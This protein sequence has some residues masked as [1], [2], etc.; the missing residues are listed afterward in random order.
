[1]FSKCFCIFVFSFIPLLINLL[2]VIQSHRVKLE[3]PAVEPQ[4]NSGSTDR[5]SRW[6]WSDVFYRPMFIMPAPQ[7]ETAE[8]SRST[9]RQSC[10]SKTVTN[11][12]AESSGQSHH[13]KYYM[14]SDPDP[15][16]QLHGSF[17]QLLISGFWDFLW[18]FFRFRHGYCKGNP[19]KMVRTW[20]EKE[21]RNLI[22]S[23]AL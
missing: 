18:F 15:V 5:F 13:S 16:S 19:R 20:A 21:M 14:T 2:I 10:S 12:S 8:P 17:H 1:M 3:E 9:R 22:R 6:M 4:R 23:E 7:Q 11:M